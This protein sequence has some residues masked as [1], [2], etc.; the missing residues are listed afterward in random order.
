PGKESAPPAAAPSVAALED[1]AP[2]ARESKAEATM[3]SK[4]APQVS[5]AAAAVVETAD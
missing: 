1:A 2:E 3:E 4:P 5:V